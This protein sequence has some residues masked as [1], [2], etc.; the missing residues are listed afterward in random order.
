[1]TLSVQGKNLETFWELTWEREVS[2]LDT[3][4]LTHL[5]TS[6]CSANTTFYSKMSFIITFK[7]HK[8]SSK[9][10]FLF[11]CCNM[12]RSHRAIIKQ[13]LTD[14]NHCTTR[15]DMSIYLHAIIAC[16]IQECMP[17]L[18]SCSFHVAVFTLCSFVRSF[19]RSGMCPLLCLH[20]RQK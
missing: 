15:A 19:P 20:Y 4:F 7:I 12:F 1:M 17:V 18:S 10:R 8:M 11:I 14:W 6:I 2:L 16:H 3:I 13:P 5:L 9:S